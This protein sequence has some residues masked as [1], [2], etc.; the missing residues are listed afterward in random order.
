M[1]KFLGSK[2]KSVSNSESQVR[3][4]VHGF[5]KFL[6]TYFKQSIPPK[7][8]K[9]FTLSLIKNYFEF[10]DSFSSLISELIS[11]NTNKLS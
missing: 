10:D 5:R 4:I 2:M 1:I 11:L 6:F 8:K 7:I 3:S 9:D